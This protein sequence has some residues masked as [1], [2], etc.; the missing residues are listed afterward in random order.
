MT[1]EPCQQP[2]LACSARLNTVQ[3][4]ITNDM[5]PDPADTKP[6]G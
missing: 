5:D 4:S 1:P 3:A 2:D 6:S